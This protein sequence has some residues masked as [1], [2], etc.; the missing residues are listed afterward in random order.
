MTITYRVTKNIFDCRS[1]YDLTA[2]VDVYYPE[3]QNW[4]WNKVVPTVITGDSEIIVAEEHD[5][6]VGV[7]MTKGGDDPKI[8]CLRVRED[9]ANRGI[10]IHLLDKGLKAVNSDKPII[11]V[12]EE[13]IHDLS[14]ILVNRFSFDLLRVEKGLYRPGKL[15][16]QF[17]GKDDQKIKSLY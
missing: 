17:N 1:V 9:Y 8:R 10:G 4:F 14:R 5:Q 15:E 13:R 3:F 11:T 12:P 6:M 2:S 7:I 16:Y